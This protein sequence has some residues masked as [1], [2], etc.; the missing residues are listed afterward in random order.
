MPEVSRRRFVGSLGAVGGA[1]WL[2]QPDQS[3]KA[4]SL[5]DQSSMEIGMSKW[6]LDTPSLCVDLDKLDHNLGVVR[7]EMDRAGIA[8]RP[9]AK[10]HKCPAIARLQ[11]ANG[12]VGV[13]VA[14]LTEAEA[15]FEYGIDQLLLT[16]I[17]ASPG[18]IRRAM[19]LRKQCD[20]FIQSVD[21]PANARDLSAA[22]RELGAFSLISPA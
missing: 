1:M 6:D 5:M 11:L 2:T 15:M 14:K 18:K 3:T 21:T 22:A 8:S 16:T 17:N 10:T 7:A 20:D 12:A 13:C 4:A 19:N 9:H